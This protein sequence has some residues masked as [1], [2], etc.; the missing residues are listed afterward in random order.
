MNKR[1]MP[2]T[3]YPNNLERSYAR[4]IE[5]MV[6]ALSR[7]VLQEFDGL[8][9]LMDEE[10]VIRDGFI[11]DD[12]LSDKVKEVI[13]KI[14]SLSLGI[15]NNKD[16]QNTA[17]KHVKG[18]S[19]VNKSNVS[20]Q[21]SVKGINPIE[22][23]PWLEAYLDTKTAENVS[24][25]TNIRDEYTTKIEQTIYRGMTEGKS[26]LEVRDELIKQTGMSR[27]KSK[28]IARDQTGTLLGQMTAKRHQNA[29]IPA[30]RWKDSDDAAVRDSHKERDEKVYYYED[31]PLLPGTDFNCRCVA[32]PV[33]EDEL[34]EAER[35]GEVVRN[36][37]AAEEQKVSETPGDSWKKTADDI[38]KKMDSGVETLKDVKEIGNKFGAHVEQALEDQLKE[39][40]ELNNRVHYLANKGLEEIYDK[41]AEVKK[42]YIDQY[43]KLVK[44]RD[45]LYKKVTEERKEFVKEALSEFREVGLK[46][47]GNYTK[48][49]N[50][51]NKKALNVVYEYLPREWVEK[52]VSEPLYTPKVTRGYQSKGSLKFRERW[53]KYGYA[54]KDLTKKYMSS[55]Y[56]TVAL[57]GISV[58]SKLRVAFHE[59]GHLAETFIRSI[60]EKEYEFYAE[61]TEGEE[62][63]W[64]GAGYK[65]SEKTRF[66]NFLSPY[67]GKD[68]GNTEESYYELL[69]MG[70]ESIYMGSYNL[71]E[72]TDY[73][74]FV[75]GILLTM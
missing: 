55:Y 27:N 75:Y 71:N 1:R 73:R 72:D 30:F 45:T 16:V 53:K 62:L 5:S 34:E 66:D 68:Y 69:S 47:K 48:F 26:S 52:F 19:N 6:V 7:A 9:K 36:S 41:P 21:I 28:F 15:F 42:E 22:A 23:E 56:N 57:S 67:M 18:V 17:S 49:S 54:E 46:T 24:Y 51:E 8:A 38:K 4:N 29:G 58:E 43:N 59:L 14:K 33:Y 11:Q 13:Q 25:I 64:L 39:Y 35:N 32:E 12:A 70:L 65:E 60:K 10:N 61:R 31:N 3:R 20:S 37:S 44:Q 63:Q 40:N 2:K 50:V 74:D